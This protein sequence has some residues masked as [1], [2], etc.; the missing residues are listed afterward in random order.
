[1]SVIG[2]IFSPSGVQAHHMETMLTSL[3]VMPYDQKGV[4]RSDVMGLAGAILHTNS[5]SQSTSQPHTSDCERFCAVF[6]GYLL[7]P[8]EVTVDLSAKGQ[9]P[10][11][12]SDAEIALLAYKVWGEDCARRLEGEFSLIIADMQKGQLF[13]ARD[14]MGFLP[15]YYMQD[16]GRLIL[17]SDFRTLA[18]L[19][20]KPL[21][22][23]PAYLAQIM[24]NR[25]FMKEATPWSEVKR[26]V[27]AHT[28]SFDGVRL[29]KTRYWTPPTN[30][31][32]RYKTDEEYAEHYRELLFDC[33]K[34]TS[35]SHCP[36]GIA[37]S[38]GLDSSALYIVAD[39]LEQK[40]E[41]LAPGLTGYSLAAEEG[42]N[43]F[44]LPFARA[45][46]A[47]VGR[48]LVEVPLF[49]PDI[50]WYE[51]DAIFHH[52]LV[53]PSNGAMMLDME[54]RVVSDGGRVIINGVGGD[55]WLTGNILDYRE[56]VN[57]L[58]PAA[59]LRALKSDAASAGWKDSV[60]TAV[61]Q[62]AGELTPEFMR[63]G[64]RARFRAKNRAEDPALRWLADDLREAIIEAEE[65]YE[66]ELP[67]AAVDWAK[68]N[69]AMSPFSDLSYSLMRRQRALIGVESRHPM[70]ARRFIEF[71]LQTPTHIKRR[72]AVTKHVHRMAMADVM[73]DKILNRTSKANFTN[74]KIDSQFAEYLR[75]NAAE[76]L[77]GVCK[78]EE[79]ESI[80]KLD[81]NSPEGDYWAWEIWGLY[82]SA[83]FLYQSR[84]ASN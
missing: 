30:I 58:D 78:I 28:L 75:N 39:R 42:C 46:A 67:S 71:S 49:D 37:V 57:D 51:K 81:F 48:D 55:E 74:S 41:W 72:G 76:Q 26:L 56:Y 4:W 5:P 16:E 70:L 53:I 54:Q 65:A 18:A 68:H 17:A 83:A 43:A 34:R 6:D 69:M 82:A 31:S 40:G 9:S 24:T 19:S 80:L 25:W 79:L 84:E 11:N 73:P 32:I 47:H 13:A 1:M 10:K 61:R 77:H 35:R 7:N 23:N 59:F 45:A 66:E 20:S 33:V 63:Q 52:D 36:V 8:D 22:P 12:G 14:H 3:S 21:T 38:G 15:L 60:A 44:E 62:V 29:T 2:A 50:D 27:R 64:I